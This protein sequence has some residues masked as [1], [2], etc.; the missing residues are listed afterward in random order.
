M[1]NYKEKLSSDSF[2]ALS[3]VNKATAIWAFSES[4]LGGLLHALKF[5]FRGMIIS[6]SAIIL[7]GVIAKYLEKRGQIIKSTI[8]V[9]LIKA[10]ISPHSPKISYLSLLLQGLFGEVFLYP[11]KFRLALSICFGITVSLFNG[12]QKIFVLTIIYGNTLWKTINDFFNYIVNDWL[13]FNLNISINFSFWIISLYVL[14]HLII[15]IT[16]GVLS[17]TIPIKLEEKL[18]NTS[19]T[20]INIDKT[21][22]QQET[23]KR[24]KKKKAKL[25]TILIFSF[26]II[27]IV[28]SYF[29][30]SLKGFKTSPILIMLIRSVII[31]ILWFY[32]ISPYINKIFKKY[33]SKKQNKYSYEINSFISH[34]SELKIIAKVIWDSTLEFKGLKRIK[35]FLISF[36][37]YVFNEQ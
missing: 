33:I 31:F 10:A 28:L 30:P 26:S 21:R 1:L 5:P 34:F 16:A 12:F 24:K 25:T 11:K 20:Q 23:F 19:L 36:L 37:V 8:Q 4:T 3:K 2:S 32:F 15:G 9:I 22:T 27:L 29:S 18:K 35:M 14:I 6:S 17:Y 13:F 7:I